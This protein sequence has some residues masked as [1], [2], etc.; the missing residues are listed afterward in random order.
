MHAFLQI[1]A[2]FHPSKSV[3]SSIPNTDAHFRVML[4]NHVPGMFEWLPKIKYLDRYESEEVAEDA[5]TR[6]PTIWFLNP[7]TVRGQSTRSPV[8]HATAV[9]LHPELHSWRENNIQY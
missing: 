7:T 2:L 3:L 8:L 5:Q 1:S 4:G 6:S 9:M